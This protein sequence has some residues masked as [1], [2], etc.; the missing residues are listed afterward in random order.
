MSVT[1]RVWEGVAEGFLALAQ[2]AYAVVAFG[3]AD[4]LDRGEY[5]GDAQT[6]QLAEFGTLGGEADQQEHPGEDTPPRSGGKTKGAHRFHLLLATGEKGTPRC[7][8]VCAWRWNRFRCRML[9][10][11]GAERA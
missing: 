9:G 1:L 8:G 5:L 6:L 10:G 4:P 3:V 2:A 7:G 11:A